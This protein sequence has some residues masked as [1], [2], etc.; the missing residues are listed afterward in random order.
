[1]FA[2]LIMWGASCNNR[3][4]HHFFFILFGTHFSLCRNPIDRDSMYNNIWRSF[5]VLLAGFSFSVGIINLTNTYN[6]VRRENNAA[7]FLSSLFN[8]GML[9]EHKPDPPTWLLCP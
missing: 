5:V 6:G 7:G 2:F 9:G 8:F 1:M 4:Q 3:A